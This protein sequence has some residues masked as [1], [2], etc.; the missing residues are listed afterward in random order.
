MTYTFDE[1]KQLAKSFL[2]KLPNATPDQI[3]NGWH[4]FGVAYLNTDMNERERKSEGPALYRIINRQM[5]AALMTND[6]PKPLIPCDG[7]YCTPEYKDNRPTGRVICPMD[8]P[9]CGLNGDSVNEP[10]SS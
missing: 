10:L 8:C 5:D 4:M 9:L 2:D 7:P 6:E 1:L 3:A